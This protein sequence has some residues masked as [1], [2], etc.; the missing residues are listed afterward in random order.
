MK[1]KFSKTSWAIKPGKPPGARLGF[2]LIELLVVIAIIAILAAMLLPALS[3]AKEK[4]KQISCAANLKQVGLGSLIYAGDSHDKVVP[5]G[6]S[7]SGSPNFPLQFN[8]GNVSIEGWKTVGVDVTQTNGR[9]V[10]TCPNRP[11]FPSYNATY[12]QYVIGYQYYGGIPKWK[13]NLSGMPSGGWLSASPIKTT[14]SK[15]GWVLAADVVAQKGGITSGDW[16]PWSQM[17]AHKG[18]SSVPDGGNEVFIDGSA[19]WIKAKTMTY[20]HSWNESTAALYI[21]QEDLGALESKR[22]QLDT[23]N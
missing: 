3:K 16:A 1:T 15:P 2:T 4:A 13:N 21:Y 17:P 12:N 18:S 22:A 7:G 14:L 9:S 11:N 5:A 10:W 8:I 19:R 23:V 6:Q 20:V